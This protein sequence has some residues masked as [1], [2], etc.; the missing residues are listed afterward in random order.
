MTRRD[1]PVLGLG[2]GLGGLFAEYHSLLIGLLLGALGAVIIMVCDW[3][4][5]RDWRGRRLS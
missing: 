4:L 5:G 3:L 2:A 1:A